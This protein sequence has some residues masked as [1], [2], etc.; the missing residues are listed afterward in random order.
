MFMSTSANNG[1]LAGLPARDGIVGTR[2]LTVMVRLRT[3]LSP[4]TSTTCGGIGVAVE[5]L[6]TL[7]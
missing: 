3:A 7:L 4:R 5:H 2:R 6:R 1:Y